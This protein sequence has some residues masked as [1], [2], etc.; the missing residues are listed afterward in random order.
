MSILYE[1]IF[2]TNTYVSGRSAGR[3]PWPL[4][5]LAQPNITRGVVGTTLAAIAA[6]ADTP[7]VGHALSYIFEPELRSASHCYTL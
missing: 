5:S 7:D 3:S 4:C 2:I 6:I 1:H